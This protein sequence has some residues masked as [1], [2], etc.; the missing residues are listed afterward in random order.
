M[1]QQY[2]RKCSLL[3]LGPGGTAG[4]N[5]SA[6]IAA[7]N[8]L[9][10]SEMHIKFKTTQQDE[11]SP[12]NCQIRVHNLSAATMQQVSKEFTRV[13]LQAGYEGNFGVIFDGTIKQF[14]IGRENGVDTYL[15]IL[16]ADGDI[17][18]NFAY[19]NTT[20]AA[21][22]SAAQ[23]RA[24]IIKKLSTYGVTLG[25]DLAPTGGILPRGKVLMGMPKAIMRTE[26]ASR[27]C[28]WNIQNGKVN[29]I[30]LDGVLPGEAVVLT[31]ETGLIHVPESTVDGIKVKCLLNPKLEVG[32]QL[33]IDN[34]SINKT[35]AGLTNPANVAFNTFG[36]V[37]RFADV[38][39]DGFY[40]IYVT[41]HE[42]DTRGQDWYS[43]L[44]CL[45]MD[46]ST[47]K[48]KPYGSA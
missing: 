41:E 7:G 48:V 11:E 29:I 2:G 45:A 43:N 27:K 32:A 18:Y 17:A 9:D 42:G 31:A 35:I 10:L 26:V 30:P 28:T 22:S 19:M 5:P 37:Q 36:G 1:S 12:N 3:V 8:G 24:E 25:T 46:P 47:K 33:Q 38:T 15:D 20:V 39:H 16:A 23:R 44:I 34:A 40:R 6:F 14:R 21:G 13:V 4:N